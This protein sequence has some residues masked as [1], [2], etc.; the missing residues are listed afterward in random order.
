M[1]WV[2][3][4]S[5][6]AEALSQPIEQGLE[7]GHRQESGVFAVLSG[8]H[9][10]AESSLEEAI[11]VPASHEKVD[12]A[13][14]G[15]PPARGQRDVP[16]PTVAGASP[17]PNE[18]ELAEGLEHATDDGCG[19]AELS[20]DCALRQWRA[21]FVKHVEQVESRSREAE[22]G[23]GAA[24]DA[25]ASPVRSFK[26]KEGGVHGERANEHGVCLAGREGATS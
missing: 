18:T 13:T 16:F 25:K 21:G 7:V 11:D 5:A 6:C 14:D 20:H 26:S 23:E 2:V 4:G 9:V 19:D 17:S 8:R 24:R 22:S 15:E 3:K 12:G 10:G 1:P